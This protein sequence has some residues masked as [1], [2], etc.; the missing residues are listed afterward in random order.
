MSKVVIV[1]GG[2][3][4]L[5]AAASFA[6]SGWETQ[7]YEKT[8]GLRA[9]GNGFPIFQNGARVLQ[10]LVGTHRFLE[11]G[12]PL[13]KLSILR[14]SGD[15]IKTHDI[16]TVTA[17]GGMVFFKRQRL[18]DLVAS[19]A[20]DFG[21]E[22]HTGHKLDRVEG[23]TTAMFEDGKRVEADL[24]VGADGIFS[25]VRQSIFDDVPLKDHRKGAIRLLI[26]YDPAEFGVKTLREAFEHNDPSGCRVGL[27]PVSDSELYMLLVFLRGSRTHAAGRIDLPEWQEMFPTLSP[28]FARIGDKGH[29]DMYHSVEPP[30]WSRG[31]VAL[32]GDAAHGMTPALGQGANTALMTGYSLGKAVAAGGDIEKSLKRWEK[33]MRPMV[34]VVQQFAEGMTAGRFDP[35]N[36][37]FFAEP[38]IQPLLRMDVPGIF[39]QDRDSAHEEIA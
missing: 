30:H 7:V 29:A 35:K 28:F 34:S 26:P 9:A 27:Y 32:I 15:P 33:I 2:I 12:H 20:R 6:A 4:G 14:S 5:A 11:A 25:K 3:G 37:T 16:E 23:S 38:V 8:D 36:E 17:G 39:Q 10:A 1:G 21:A 31:R 24:L 13:E 19:A 22:I 18:I